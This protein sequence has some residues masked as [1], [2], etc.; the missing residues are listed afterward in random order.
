VTVPSQMSA[1]LATGVD[2]ISE[3]GE[4]TFQTYSR[5]VL[6]LDGYVF[7]SPGPT[8]TI[9]GSL[10]VSQDIE[11]NEDETV[12]LAH[13][14]FTTTQRVTEFADAPPNTIFVARVREFRFSFAQQSGRYEAAGLW[15]YSGRSI[16]PA[17]ETQLLDTPGLIDPTRAVVS[18]SM[19]LWLDFA[20]YKPVYGFT[21]KLT[22]YP[23]DLVEPN[24]TP[25]YGAVVISGPDPLTAIPALD[26][27]SSSTQVVADRV[28]I[29]LYGL[30]S[31]ESIDFLNALIQYS[32][33]TEN[34]G[35]MS[36]PC[37]VDARRTQTEL[38]AIAMQKTID[39]RVS[40]TQS[41]VNT[42]AQKLILSAVPTILL[43]PLPT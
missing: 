17:L 3:H 2:V 30:Q 19:P 23:A 16:Y 41:R 4:V 34:F 9:D 38:Q 6:P 39:V 24:L 25:P 27:N 21:P 35:L 13:V 14:V 28:R 33:D 42:V 37:V 11:Q 36:I 12:G 43:N 10:H 7:W 26:A 31:N 8:I 18:N 1:A 5:L 29:V 22:L 20:A 32:R 15:H 40:Y